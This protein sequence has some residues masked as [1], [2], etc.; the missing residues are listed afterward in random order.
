MR[1]LIVFLIR[2]YRNFISP[3]MAPRCRYLPTCSEYASE[4]ICQHGVI[5]GG[6]MALRR[7]CRC[8][9]LGPHGYD[10]VPLPGGE[11]R[12]G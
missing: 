6:G 12:H 3:L 11:R 1:A 10:P 8:H 7:L 9:P 2:L 4:A 5:K